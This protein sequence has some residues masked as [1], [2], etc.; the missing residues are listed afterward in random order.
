MRT[1]VQ[2]LLD[3]IHPVG[4]GPHD[5]LDRIGRHG[6]QLGQDAPRIVGRMFR[7]DDQPVKARGGK[8]FGHIRVRQRHPQSNLRRARAQ[9]GFE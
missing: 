1:D 3:E 4:D 5:G 8:Q 6:L 7:I 9:R 2:V